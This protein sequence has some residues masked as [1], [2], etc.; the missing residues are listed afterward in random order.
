MGF[1]DGDSIRKINVPL[2]TVIDRHG[3][4]VGV[5]DG[6]PRGGDESGADTGLVVQETE[7]LVKNLEGKSYCKM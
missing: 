1:A 6:S 4:C 7:D 3:E 5:N 2:L